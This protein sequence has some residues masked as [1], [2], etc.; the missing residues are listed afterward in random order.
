[1][2]IEPYFGVRTVYLDV[3][4]NVKSAA[5]TIAEAS[6]YLVVETIKIDPTVNLL[7]NIYE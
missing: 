7:M 6:V 3:R 2:I 1:M 4:D 5:E